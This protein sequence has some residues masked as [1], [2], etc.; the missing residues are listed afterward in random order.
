MRLVPGIAGATTAT[1]RR[2]LVPRRISK[3][4]DSDLAREVEW[5]VG[6]ELRRHKIEGVAGANGYRRG[7]GCGVLFG[8]Y[9]NR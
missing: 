2:G 1:S 6:K 9:V 7:R 4:R 8:R 3:K 5:P